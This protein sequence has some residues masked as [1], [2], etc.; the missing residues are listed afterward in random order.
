MPKRRLLQALLP[1][2]AALSLPGTA[3]AATPHGFAPH[4]VV[5]KFAGARAAHSVALPAGVGV[6]RAAAALGRSAAV[7]YAEPNY[8][9]SASAAEPPAALY[10]PNDS[11]TLSLGAK[12]AAEGDRSGDWAFRQWSFLSPEGPATPELPTSPGGIDVVGAWRNLIEAG[13]PGGEGI[14]VAV[15]DSGIAYRSHGGYLRSPDFAPWQFVHGRSYIGPGSLPLDLNGHGT[16]VAGTIAEQTENGFALTGIAYRAKLM[17]LRVLNR[18]GVG[19]SNQIAEAIRFAVDHRARVINMSLNFECGKRI[20]VVD[21]ALR[22]AYA[23]GVVTVASAGNLQPATAGGA[24]TRA[25]VSEPATGPHV[26]AV[27]GTTEGGCLGR[28]A[29]TST[30]IDLL[31][32]GGGE[33]RRGCPSVLS[34]PIYQVT[35]K[36]RAKDEFG[37]PGNYVGTSMAAAHVSGVAA[38]M[39]AG[40]ALEPREPPKA[41]VDA[42][43]R[44]LQ[45][46]ARDLGLPVRRQG[47]GLIDARLATEPV[48]P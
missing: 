45:E 32:P 9:A 8:L 47:A 20:R 18:F 46:T 41:R 40:R 4:Q 29:L 34:R 19:Y 26:I 5:V 28:Y 1:L 35:L 37:I 33:P 11:G 3:T 6:R 36:P 10:D 24:G 48:Q 44:R 42:V 30:A 22:Y 17:P 31:A 16:H 38:L 43:L 12:A 27:S 14:T 21:E 13:R 2:A 39:L 15:L 7:A 23:R 25:C